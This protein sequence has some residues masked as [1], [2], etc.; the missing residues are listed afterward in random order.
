MAHTPLGFKWLRQMYIFFIA[1]RM[2][3][4]KWLRIPQRRIAPTVISNQNS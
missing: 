4:R 2:L 3:I 1:L